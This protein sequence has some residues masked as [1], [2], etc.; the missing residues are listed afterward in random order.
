M[1]ITNSFSINMLNSNQ[2]LHFTKL[3]GW[4]IKRFTE[5]AIS[6]F[7]H[8]D[9][10]RIVSLNTGQEFKQNRISI[11]LDETSSV[12]IA[13]Y[14]GPRLPEGATQLPDGAE[15]EY[16]LVSKWEGLEAAKVAANQEYI[17]LSRS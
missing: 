13:Q 1:Y 3:S 10:A 7:G 17:K 14:R 15:I 4:N 2:K 16:W 8:E 9:I 12:L 6:A 5:V 11:S